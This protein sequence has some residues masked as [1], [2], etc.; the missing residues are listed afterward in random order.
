MTFW[1][2]ATQRSVTPVDICHLI[3]PAA[4]KAC[5]AWRLGRAEAGLWLFVFF[6]KKSQSSPI[7]AADFIL[8]NIKVLV[9]AILP[10]PINS[11]R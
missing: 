1:T 7:V 8:Q 2:P 3:V 5:S 10:I 9:G 11:N 4:D 6:F